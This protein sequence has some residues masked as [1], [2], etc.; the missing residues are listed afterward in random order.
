M[1]ACEVAEPSRHTIHVIF[2]RQIYRCILGHATKIRSIFFMIGHMFEL[3]FSF[4]FLPYA[5]VTFYVLVG[6][7]LKML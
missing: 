1:S 3:H 6:H 2:V 7:R 4:T 5:T